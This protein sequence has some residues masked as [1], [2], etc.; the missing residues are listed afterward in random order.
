MSEEPKWPSVKAKAVNLG[1][2]SIHI[3]MEGKEVLK[4]VEQ[5]I[6]AYA[7]KKYVRLTAFKGQK[8][9]LVAPG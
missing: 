8:R 2:K 7:E 6:Q 4:L 3:H 1:E 5:I 9:I